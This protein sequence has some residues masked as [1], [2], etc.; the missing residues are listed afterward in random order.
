MTGRMI[1]GLAA[2]G[3]GLIHLATAIGSPPAVAV[4]V[5]VIG[6]A[7]FG[8]GVV[9]V[10]AARIPLPTAAR[11]GAAVPIVLWALVLVVAGAAQLGPFTSTLR[12]GPMLAASALDV[13]VVV[14]VTLVRRRARG[15]I[16][17]MRPP[18]SIVAV[19]IGA[20]LIAALTALA[21]TGTEAGETFGT[22]QVFVGHQH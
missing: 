13:V 17:A 8:W 15:G 1:A 20:A 18:R 10:A 2:I 11:A 12:L 21:L 5:A 19:V 7:E 3:A 9:D 14:A 6:I 4:V 16:P 22:G